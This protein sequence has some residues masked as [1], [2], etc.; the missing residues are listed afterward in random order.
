MLVELGNLKN[1][2]DVALLTGQKNR[3]AVASAL[4]AGIQRT[5]SP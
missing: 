5:V 1:A 2:K 3:D 4:A